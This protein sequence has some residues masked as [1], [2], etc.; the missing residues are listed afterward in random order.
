MMKSK[1]RKETNCVDPRQYCDNKCC[2]KITPN[3]L[4][5]AIYEKVRKG[6]RQNKERRKDIGSDQ[7]EGHVKTIGTHGKESLINSDFQTP[8]VVASLKTICSSIKN[9]ATGA[10]EHYQIKSLKRNVRKYVSKIFSS[11]CKVENKTVECGG[12]EPTGSVVQG[13][14]L[15]HHTTHTHFTQRHKSEKKSTRAIERERKKV[16]FGFEI[17]FIFHR[18]RNSFDMSADNRPEYQDE[19]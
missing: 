5:I 6:E 8:R 10:K 9:H 12:V 7:P 1:R 13:Q 3:P 16:I 15:I 2:G 11:D 4:Q 18:R 17:V 19:E 14:A